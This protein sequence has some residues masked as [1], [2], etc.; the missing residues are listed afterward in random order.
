MTQKW[1]KSWKSSKKPS[2]QRKYR[3]NAPYHLRK[4]FLSVS[5]SDNLKEKMGTSSIPVRTGDKAEIM[6]G[7]Y[8][9]L[10]GTVD[11]VD[12]TNYKVY[13]SNIERER[14][15][16][17]ETKVAFDPSNL[18]LV[19]LELEDNKRIEKYELSEK[20]KEAI[21]IKEKEET[22]SKEESSDGK[23]EDDEES[24][25]D[26]EEEEDEKTD[27]KKEEGDK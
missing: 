24:E 7:D 16:G 12:Y 8:E 6:R 13:L 10:S 23:V 14:V 26:S 3:L 22:D 4:K 15:D 19:K 25:Q 2:K 17:T 20:E 5:L 9:G 1:K 21:K 27:S 18:R 11:R